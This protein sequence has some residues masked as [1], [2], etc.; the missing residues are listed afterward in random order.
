V[1]RDIVLAAQGG[2]RDAFAML[3]R[4][5][6]G[7]LFAIA[8]RTLRDAS[9]AEDAVQQALFVAW[10]QLPGLKDP[11]RFAAWIN[12][13]LVREAYAASRKRAKAAASTCVLPVECAAARD[14]LLSVIDRDELERGFRRLAVDERAL[15][16]LRHYVGMEPIEIA[17]ALGVAAG[18]V[19]SRLHHAHRAM[20]AALE[21]EERCAV[22]AAG[23]QSP[24]GHGVYRPFRASVE[25]RPRAG[26]WGDGPR[27]VTGA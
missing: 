13:V 19:R 6:G 20:R 14:E 11:D 8:H 4:A 18:T 10:H 2:D 5:H 22:S 26:H 25:H 3:A 17:A 1:D 23:R 16:V 24:A 15:L 21:A 9:L 12:R 27:S 7:R